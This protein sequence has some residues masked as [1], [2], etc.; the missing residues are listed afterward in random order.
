MYRVLFSLTFLIIQISL[1]AQIVVEQ[2]LSTSSILI[3]EQVELQTRVAVD[4]DDN[5]EFPRFQHQLYVPGVE[6][7]KEGVI[8]TTFLNNGSRME[9]RR[10]YLLTSFDSALYSLP[11]FHVVVS[12][13]TFYAAS[14]VGL[15]VSTV[16][17]DTA[18]ANN[19]AAPHGV[20]G[21]AYEWSAGLWS[22]LLVVLLLVVG[23]VMLFKRIA[24]N[25]PI[26]K[27]IV[28]APPPPAHQPAIEA[29][30]RIRDSR[31]IETAEDLKNYYDN[32]TD[33]LRNY[34]EKR[35]GFNA[36]EL[37]SSEIIVRLQQTNDATALRELREVLE[38]ADLVKFAKYETS[39]SEADRS[40][41]MAID[42]V[43]TTKQKPEELPVP[44][45][46]VVTIGEVKQRRVR[47]CL[48][49]I[50]VVAS[51]SALVLLGIVIK[52]LYDCFF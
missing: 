5:V 20:I 10:N 19:F 22:M 18:N 15:K 35:F 50:A 37:T 38:T 1:Q 32:L 21:I 17:V 11:P 14:S 34:I 49:A 30:E 36:L 7:L 47:I 23:I 31:Q 12:Q 28:V 3:G 9:L 46:K 27:R 29:I 45:V 33:V 2:Q 4:A 41:L 51:A 52:D 25:K 26:T 40:L 42:Y 6:I 39:L 13:D 24:A 16:P 43:N 44:E 48:I 8:D